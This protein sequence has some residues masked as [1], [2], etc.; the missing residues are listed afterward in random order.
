MIF[1]QYIKRCYKPLEKYLQRIITYHRDSESHE[2]ILRS[3]FAAYE[4]TVMKML[5]SRP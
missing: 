5:I 1:A 3:R 4:G 2:H